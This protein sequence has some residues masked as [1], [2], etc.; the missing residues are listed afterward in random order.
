MRRTLRIAGLLLVLVIIVVVTPL[1][2]AF[3]GNA[4]ITPGVVGTGIEV[5]QDGYTTVGL[6]SLGEGRYALV[7]AGNDPTGKPI[8]DALAAHGAGPDAVD[9]ILLTH[10]HPDHVA[11]CAVFPKAVT[12]V[13]SAELPY[14]HG[15]RAYQGPLPRLFGPKRADCPNVQPVADLETLN[16]GGSRITAWS[17]P[18]HTA[19]STA[20]SVGDTLFVGDAATSRAKG[21]VLGPPWVFSDDLGTADASLRSLASRL[22]AVPTR[23]VPAH[24]GVVSGAD[25]TRS[26]G[27]P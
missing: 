21:P 13:G 7:D 12:Y 24:T 16:L 14:L 22:P 15:E 25:F 20:W 26:F 9:A 11:A 4:P 3:I 18:G 27:R 23:V 17:V 1:A 5:V 19:G 2:S 8:L 6:L 10:A